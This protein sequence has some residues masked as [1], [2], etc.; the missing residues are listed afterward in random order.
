MEGCTMDNWINGIC[1]EVDRLTAEQ[2]EY[3]ELLSRWRALEPRYIEILA[4]LPEADAE[5][6]REYEYLINEM[7]YQKTQTAYRVGRQRK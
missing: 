5:V 6:L 1:D 2:P 7:H 3:R 4:A